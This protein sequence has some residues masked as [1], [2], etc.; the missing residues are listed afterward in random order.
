MKLYVYDHCPYCVKARM[1]F[2]YKQISFELITLLNDDE[3]TPT[4]MIGRKMVPILE[5]TSE[6]YMPESMDI[7]RHVDQHIGGSP[8][9][10]PAPTNSPIPDW[11]EDIREELYPLTMPRW[12]Q[13]PLAEFATQGA[14][15]YFTRKKEDYIG[16]FTS[17]LANSDRLIHRTNKKLR[18]LNAFVLSPEAV[19]GTLTEDDIHLFAALRSLSIVKGLEYPSNVDAY[20]Q[21]QAVLTDIPL[22]D[23]IAL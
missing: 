22:H 2:G 12:P 19:H 18:N 1:I 8:I 16:S 20:R 23:D 4:A 11:L 9:L 15:D 14:C 10:S 7:V 21:K 5:L 13:A 3:T 17:H 6:Q